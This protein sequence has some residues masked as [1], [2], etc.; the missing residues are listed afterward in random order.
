MDQRGETTTLDPARAT[1]T[2]L[3]RTDVN[4]KRPSQRCTTSEQWQPGV[5]SSPTSVPRNGGKVGVEADDGS[6]EEVRLKVFHPKGECDVWL[7]RAQGSFI[8]TRVRTSK[9]ARLCGS[10]RDG[11][12][13]Q[14]AGTRSADHLRFLAEAEM[15][16]VHPDEYLDTDDSDADDFEVTPGRNVAVLTGPRVH[17]EGNPMSSSA[18]RACA[19]P[20]PVSRILTQPDTEMGAVPLPVPEDAMD[21][22][23][24][25]GVQPVLVRRGAKRASTMWEERA[26]QTEMEVCVDITGECCNRDA[27]D[28][29]SWYATVGR[30]KTEQMRVRKCEMF[31]RRHKYEK[32]SMRTVISTTTSHKAKR[33][34]TQPRVVTVEYADATR[35]PE[36]YASTPHPRALRPVIS[37]VM[38]KCRTRQLESCDTSS[39]F[40]HAWLKR[41]VW[42]KPPKDPRLRD[43]WC[44]QLASALL[45]LTP[46][47][48]SQWS[49]GGA[50][51]VRDVKRVESL[52]GLSAVRKSKPSSRASGRGQCSVLEDVD[53]CRESGA[54]KRHKHCLVPRTRQV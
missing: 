13:H 11:A 37:R 24:D 53:S 14:T 42:V 52:A 49:P 22:D 19:N 20:P 1:R 17:L 35:V 9:E 50:R 46:G 54:P 26:D 39:A 2:S 3:G 18:K 28:T 29:L 41:G 43:G 6:Q 34:E 27:V 51:M 44:W 15:R 23:F 38:S 33:D 16:A 47:V 31:R 4:S 21:V 7:L 25:A 10:D 5:L 12:T 48:S 32:S 8:A 30:I 36:H 45:L 40:F